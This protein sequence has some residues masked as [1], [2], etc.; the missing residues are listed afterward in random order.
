MDQR[1]VSERPDYSLLA[2]MNDLQQEAEQRCEQ[3]QDAVSQQEK[4]EAEVQSLT[5]A[6]NEAKEKLLSSHVQAT[7][8]PTLK[9][10]IYEHNVRVMIRDNDKKKKRN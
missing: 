4:F 5:G 1:G 3:L 8:M 6:I 9:K 2:K 10:Q 7:D